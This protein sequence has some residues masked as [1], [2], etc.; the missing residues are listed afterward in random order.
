MSII[1]VV[2]NKEN[3]Y[4]QLN[5]K[6]L[7]NTNLSL[8]AIGLWARCLTR[9]DDWEFNIAEMSKSGKEGKDAIRNAV[10]EL[11][12]EGYA[13]RIANRRTDTKC[14]DSVIYI[15]FEFPISEEEKSSYGEEFK[16]IFPQ[17]EKPLMANP[18]M[19]NPPLLKKE[20]ELKKDKKL[21]KE[22]EGS[23]TPLPSPDAEATFDFFLKKIRERSPTFKDPNKK[24]WIKSFDKLFRLDKRP[25]HEVRKLIE[26][27]STHKWWSIACLSA[28]KLRKEYDNML[29]QMNAEIAANPQES[30]QVKENTKFVESV[31]EYLKSERWKIAVDNR[32]FAKIQLST[33]KPEHITL[34]MSPAEFK[35]IALDY[36]GLKEGS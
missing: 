17:P 11:I 18:I 35:R 23:N 10:N 7:W 24:Q 27:A 6:A 12:K 2:H 36:L 9:P 14:F 29:I 19:A 31:Q 32:G 3:P 1:R 13:L 21:K 22:E 20:E 8:K 28:D 15:I 33:G 5:K 16:K 26:W 30:P 25:V 34:N 4:V